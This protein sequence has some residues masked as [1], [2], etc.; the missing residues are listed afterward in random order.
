VAF[1]DQ[2]RIVLQGRSAGSD[3]GD[4]LR[5]L[6]H[7]LA[8]LAL[9]EFQGNL[10][11]RWFDE[12]YASYAAAE[13]GREEMLATNVALALR[14]MP[15]LDELEQSFR[16]GSN[17]AQWA[18]ALAYRA[19]AELAQIDRE[20]GLALFLQYWREGG[21]LDR[22]LRRAYGLTLPAYEKRW[23]D[24]TRTQYGALA[25][26]SNVTIGGLLLLLVLAPL[27]VIRKR[28]DRRRLE[29]MREADAIAEQAARQSAL[30]ALLGEP[31]RDESP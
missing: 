16:G 5:V 10:P 7:E 8:H 12:G 9:H 21:S 24:R 3:A 22:A 27:Y 18:Y 2:R 1:P 6:R 11:P 31:P 4:P 13:W 14:G 15:S 25:L 23:A 20:R 17:A 28:R 19:V 29:K 30:E 26:V